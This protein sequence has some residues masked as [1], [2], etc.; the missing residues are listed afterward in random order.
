[1][2][3]G[4]VPLQGDVRQFLNLTVYSLGNGNRELREPL[5]GHQ[6]PLADAQ[7]ARHAREAAQAH[8]GPEVHDVDSL[9]A[10]QLGKESQRLEPHIRD[11]RR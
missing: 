3:I 4:D 11:P 10:A 6:S 1:M 5:A 8:G 9:N 2:N 7:R